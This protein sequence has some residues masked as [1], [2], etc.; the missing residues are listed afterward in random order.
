SPLAGRRGVVFGAELGVVG[1][2]NGALHALREVSVRDW[3]EGLRR[4]YA[5][6][7][8]AGYC[9]RLLEMAVEPEHPEPDLYDLLRRALD[10]LS[11]A[12]ASIK[13]ML[14]FESELA[15]LLGVAHDTRRAADCLVDLLGEL[16]SARREL[17][18][19]LSSP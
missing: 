15:R 11:A 6:T 2:R 4:S 5:T 16:P 13:A 17:L 18:D 9:C 12:P 3:R 14:H 8:L 10:H 1:A 7:L 19:R